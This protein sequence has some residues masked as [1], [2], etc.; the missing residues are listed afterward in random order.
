MALFPVEK[1][2]IKVCKSP[3]LSY[4]RIILLMLKSKITESMLTLLGY[5]L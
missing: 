4:K 1:V 5:H 2:E 3:A